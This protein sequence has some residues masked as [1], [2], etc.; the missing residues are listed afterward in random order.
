MRNARKA[1]RASVLLV[2]AVMALL[3]AC[4]GGRSSSETEQESRRGPLVPMLM[5]LEVPRVSEWAKCTTPNTP[6]A[7]DWI[8][9]SEG[10]G[11]LV[12]LP[13][14]DGNAPAHVLFV[15]TQN[16]TMQYK[17]EEL[18][19]D[20]G[21]PHRA[22]VKISRLFPDGSVVPETEPLNAHL[23]LDGRRCRPS[24]D[25]GLAIARVTGEKPDPGAVL[26]GR[27]DAKSGVAWGRL[28]GN[29]SYALAV[30]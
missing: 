11:G 13:N 6:R 18:P 20:P 25:G 12:A 15:E 1:V 19:R 26:P 24:I 28:G 9:I 14:A 3:V 21:S 27:G 23:F 4:A 8:T 16:P 22:E 17:I 29:S 30:P 5:R 10:D 2:V 7:S